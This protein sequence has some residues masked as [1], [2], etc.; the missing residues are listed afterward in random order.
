MSKKENSAP[1]SD[2]VF[3]HLTYHTIKSGNYQVFA[4]DFEEKL[5][6]FILA[7]NLF[8]FFLHFTHDFSL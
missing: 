7:E 2:F 5:K 4:R 6:I 1:S 3:S 8:A